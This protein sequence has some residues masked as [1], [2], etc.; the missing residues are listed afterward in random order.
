MDNT[1]F[2]VL[3]GEAPYVI[4]DPQLFSDILAY[5]VNNLPSIIDR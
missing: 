2:I 5:S 1:L 4:D 3:T